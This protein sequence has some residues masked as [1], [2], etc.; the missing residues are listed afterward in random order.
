VYCSTRW[1]I[2]SQRWDTIYGVNRKLL[3]IAEG[4]GR[5]GRTGTS[6]LNLG[7]SFVDQGCCLASMEPAA[8]PILLVSQLGSRT[9]GGLGLSCHQ[10]TLSFFLFF[11][12]TCVDS[13]LNTS[14]HWG[15]RGDFPCRL[16]NLPIGEE[17]ECCPN[18][19]KVL[20]SGLGRWDGLWWIRSGSSAGSS[21]FEHA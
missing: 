14:V 15:G 12:R 8:A 7:M 10:V 13:W 17:G 19:E 20:K 9:L 3:W 2:D 21:K 18:A 6:E 5:T 11:F 16:A 4:T 1:I